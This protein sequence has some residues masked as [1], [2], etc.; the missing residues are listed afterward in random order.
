[1][2]RECKPPARE[3]GRS[4]WRAARQSRRRPPPAP[5]RPP[6]SALSDL[7][8]RSPPH[9]RSSPHSRR[10]HAG[11]DQRITSL[12]A[13][14]PQ[15]HRKS[16]HRFD[17]PARPVRRQQLHAFRSPF[18]KGS[19]LRPAIMR[20]DPGLAAS[21]LCG[22][23]CRWR[24]VGN[25]VSPI[26]RCGRTTLPAKWRRGAYGDSVGPGGSPMSPRM[27][28]RNDKFHELQ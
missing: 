5:T 15:L 4:G 11:R 23:N 10:R 22:V 13:E 26:V 6:T 19:G 14:C 7:L 28:P 12:C 27:Q 16:H 1:M 9:A 24:G 20:H 17:V 2:V 8:R 21:P 3:P 25:R 18:P